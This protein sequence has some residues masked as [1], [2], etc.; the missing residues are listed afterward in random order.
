MARSAPTSSEDQRADFARELS[1]QLSAAIENIQLLDEVLRQRRLLEDTFNSLLDLVVVTDNQL[2][3]RADERGVRD[4][5]R[6]CRGPSCWIGALDSL[7][8]PELAA[9]AATADAADAASGS[10]SGPAGSRIP[11]SAARCWSR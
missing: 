7:V 4:A 8:G 3:D 1:R 2:R 10:R 11:G 5:R 9:W 6:R